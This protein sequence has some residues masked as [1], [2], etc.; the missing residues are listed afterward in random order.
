MAKTAKKPRHKTSR[1]ASIQVAESM[2]SGSAKIKKKIRDIERL[3][4]N[5]PNLPADKKIEYDRGLKALQVELK[6]SQVQ[7]KAK[8]ISKKYHMVRFFEKKKATRK[9]K[10]LRKEF[11]EI[12]K[13]GVRKDIKKARKQLKHGEIDLAYVILFPKTE[14]Y[15]S[16]YPSPNN[17]DQTDPNVIKGLKKTEERRR[18][19]R[20][21]VEKLIDED[22]LPFSIDD[23]LQGKSVRLDST[24]KQNAVI[25]EEIDAPEAKQNGQK[26]EQDDFFE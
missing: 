21:S 12:S 2:G 17:E 18:E 20:K 3:I 15:I 10:N 8:I 25:T 23:I 1:G 14:K 9:L 26:E 13:T 7:N 5:N 16:L 4:K 6:N 22:K 19:F 11:E 24:K